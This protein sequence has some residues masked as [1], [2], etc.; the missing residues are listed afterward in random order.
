MIGLTPGI[1]GGS[2]RHIY[3][4]SSR[5][6]CKVL[7]QRRSICKNKIEIPILSENGFLMNISFF[8]SVFIYCF[9]LLLKPRK[10][11]DVIHI[12]ENLLY[13]AVPFLKFRYTVVVTVHG[14]SGFNFYDNKFLWFFFSN[15]LKYANK[16]ISVSVSDKD[17]L[18]K[19][20]SNVEYV[21]NGVETNV[22]EKISVKKIENKITFVGRIHEQKGISFL[23][24]A[25]SLIKNDFPS[26]RLEIIGKKEGKLYDKLKSNYDRK[27]IIWRG[28]IL[29]RKAL[30]SEIA[31]SKILVFPSLWEALPWP[32]LLEGLASG[33]PVIASDLNGMRKIFKD[34][35]DIF[36]VPPSDSKALAE[37]IEKILRNNKLENSL[38]KNGK[39]TAKKYTWDFI[40]LKVQ[41]VYKSVI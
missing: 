30:F 21:P 22:Y 33:R 13:L 1:E 34:K 4:I 41:K 32:A 25:F 38:G 24:E 36:L 8:I 18:E 28:F 9:Y 27:G 16:I 12:H 7:T 19:I 20:F 39:L 35:K 6:N 23:L 29:D 40:S 11:F 10:E 37:A 17:T 5:I 31:S 26:Y 3:E 14:I 15:S 2:Q